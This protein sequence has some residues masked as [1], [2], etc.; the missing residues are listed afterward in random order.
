MEC[1]LGSPE[2][3]GLC[4]QHVWRW[5]QGMA[6]GTALGV[7]L[8]LSLTI[9]SLRDLR[10]SVARLDGKL[11]GGVAELAREFAR[12]RELRLCAVREAEEAGR[13]LAGAE[14]DRDGARAGLAALHDELEAKAKT[15][16][17]V[18]RELEGSLSR[19]QSRLAD[20]AGVAKRMDDA[21]H[22]T[23]GGAVRFWSRPVGARFES[24]QR[25][26]QTSIPII[27]FANQKGG[28][29]KTTTVANLAACFAGRGERVLTID[30][31][32]QGSHS[33]MMHLQ[34]GREAEEPESLIDL[35][36]EDEL[37]PDWSGRA[38]RKA[39]N[40]LYYIPAFYAF[41]AVE[42]RV[43]YRWTLGAVADDARYRL[44]RALLAKEVQGA[45]DRV[46]IDAPPRFTLGFVNGFCAATH[47]YTPT[48][49]DHVSALAV[50]L[51][52]RQ[53]CE[54]K[55]IV[56]PHIQWPGIIGTLTTTN[57]QNPLALPG[58]GE[59]AAKAAER[60]AQS[61][62]GGSDPVFIRSPVIKRE[63]TIANA[64]ERGVAYLNAAGV[65]PMFDALANV[66]EQRA[67]GK[68]LR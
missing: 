44:A 2:A 58:T 27:M 41:E 31:D 40:N 30:L 1:G 28:V 21:L 25:D 63:T 51:F 13:R 16:D 10:R 47:L 11:A 49:V 50:E 46:L 54:L 29:G 26:I 35:L 62:T 18:R 61:R 23:S 7:L 48:V 32:Y 59:H 4:A 24:Y 45:F 5:L 34:A 42:R 15:F 37:A 12:E 55:A 60:H 14:H 57:T 65:R 53:F 39:A 38:I 64:S 33:R 3:L 17:A 19:A 9:W 20:I 52:A 66:I 43:E 22:D 56:N 8:I 68:G 67:P 36:F 6:D